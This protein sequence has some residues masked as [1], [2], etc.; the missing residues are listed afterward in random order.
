LPEPRKDIIMRTPTQWRAPQLDDLDNPPQPEP[1]S[2][3]LLTGGGR[4]IGRLAAE[5]LAD[6]GMAVGLIARSPA[7]LD[8]TV[9]E[10]EADDD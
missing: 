7:E 5:A 10:M 2:V 3:A 8:E 4:G 6:S 1:G 9:A